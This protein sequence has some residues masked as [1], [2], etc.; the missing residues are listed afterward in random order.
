MKMLVGLGNP[1]LEY[2]RTRHNVGFMVIERLAG[3]TG[4][5]GTVRSR[6]HAACVEGRIAGEKCLLV[7]PTTYMNRSGMAVAEAVAFFK[8]VEVPRDLMVITDDLA[9]PTGMI[10]IRPGGGA[11]GHNG[12]GDIERALGT[13]QYPRLRV[14]IGMQPAGGK[15]SVMNQADFVLS[16]F[17]HEEQ[18]LLEKAIE[19]ACGALE[20]F[21]SRGVDA[22]MNKYNVKN[23][24]A[25][26]NATPPAGG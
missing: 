26:E 9:L 19:D 25:G 17:I 13:D 18:P 12:L 15:P 4:I 20:L 3:K 7:R 21:I 14:G 1:G 22:A 5:D 8:T 2:A 23:S 10:R 24:G 11:G 16:R 6:F